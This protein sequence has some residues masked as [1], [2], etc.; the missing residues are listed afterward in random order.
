LSQEL[1]GVSVIIITMGV[2]GAGKST[3]GSLL[4]QRL[5]WEFADAD[6]YH[7]A[8]NIEKMSNGVPLTD[9][10][11]APWLETLRRLIG[12]WLEKNQNAVLACSALKRSYRERLH[13]SDAVCFLYL[14]VA[15]DVL[16]QRLL[17][18][19]GHY[20]KEEMLASQLD[21]LEEPEQ[22]LVVNGG[23]TPNAIVGEILETL[24]LAAG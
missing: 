21:A 13:V 5:R 19:P 23:K 12:T 16:V 7:P 17:A 15:R 4:A 10:D 24:G 9:A 6:D 11:R 22:A 8:R 1:I 2:S 3:I 18:R 20:M 14:K